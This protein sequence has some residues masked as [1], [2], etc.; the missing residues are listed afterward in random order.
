VTE[1][2]SRDG[3]DTRP[4]PG[5]DILA[6]AAVGNG[7]AAPAEPGR[8]APSPSPSGGDLAMASWRASLV[9]HAEQ[10]LSRVAA[11]GDA[12][13]AA[14]LTGRASDCLAVLPQQRAVAG[15]DQA[16]LVWALTMSSVFR[17]VLGQVMAA[18]AD[19][20]EAQ[21][22]CHYAAPLL[23]DPFWRFTGIVCHWLEGGWA[24]AQTEIAALEAGQLS[25]VT[26]MFTEIIAALRTELLRG[27]D[28]PPERAQLAGQLTTA[29]GTGLAAWALAGLDIDAGHPEAAVRRLAEACGD[30]AQR[31]VHG[32]V[33]PLM[34]HRMAEAG[35][36][37]GDRDVTQSAAAALAALDRA[38]PLTEILAGLAQAY[39]TGDPGPARAAQQRAEAEGIRT[40]AAEA[41]AVRGRIGDEP[42][43][44]LAAAYV[45]WHRLGIPGRAHAIAAAMSAAGLPVP[46]ADRQAS[47]G[48]AAGPVPLT[49]RERGLARLV[50]E[51]RTNQQIAHAL[52]IS[53][54]TVEAYLTRLYRKTSC[55]SRVELAV[56]VTE[57]RIP[58]DD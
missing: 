36:I 16:P 44:T 40:L 32:P 49:A 3:Q 53:V 43:V 27:L 26:P 14:L 21:R 7:S 45:A 20:A 51:G 56:A 54:K 39:A 34:L 35:Y 41:L 46:V 11:L 22:V 55:A 4:D 25:P 18:R 30:A 23:A 31:G 10:R 38:A 58:L 57:Q 6:G 33:L 2:H 12:A 15:R 17:A 29:T 24:A 37:H 8:Q 48:A 50:Y 13:Q 42:A 47:L 1:P 19:L 5:V 9:D 52:D 28:R